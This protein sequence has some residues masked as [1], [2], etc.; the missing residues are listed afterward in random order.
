MSHQTYKEKLRRAMEDLKE[1]L[2]LEKDAVLSTSSETETLYPKIARVYVR[3]IVLAN[4]IEDCHHNIVHPQERLFVRKVLDALLVRLLE[5]KQKVIATSPREGSPHLFLSEVL[6]FL[7]ISPEQAVLRIPR[8]LKDDPAVAEQWDVKMQ[9]LEYWAT[10][11]RADAL[12]AWAAAS[13]IQA[14]W[15]AWSCR[16][17][18]EKERRTFL[19]FWG[20]DFVESAKLEDEERL[21]EQVFAARKL[22]QRE[23]GKAYHASLVTELEWLRENVGSELKFQKFA[24]GRDWMLEFRRQ[25]GSFPSSFADRTK[26]FDGVPPPPPDGRPYKI[27]LPGA[28]K[29]PEAKEKRKAEPSKKPESAREKKPAAVEPSEETLPTITDEL[30][31]LAKEFEATWAE[32]P[33]RVD[34]AQEPDKTLTRNQLLPQVESEVTVAVDE[35]LKQEL[36]RLRQQFDLVKEKPRKKGQKTGG[37]K[38]GKKGGTA[39]TKCCNA[40]NLAGPLEDIFPDLVKDGILRGVEP[41]KL[42]DFIGNFP[43]CPTPTDEFLPAPT[44]WQIKQFLVEQI[45]LPLASTSIREKT[46]FPARS[47]LLYG[48]PGS[49]KSLISRIIATEAG[50]MF[51]DLSPDVIENLYKHPKTGASLM[52]HKTFLCAQQHAP[53]VIYIDNVDQVFMSKKGGKKKGAGEQTQS[54]A[55][56]IRDQLKGHLNLVKKAGGPLSASDRLLVIGCTSRPFADRLDQKSMTDFFDHKLWLNFP[57]YETRK[58]IWESLLKKKHARIETLGLANLSTLAEMSDGYSGGALE[59]AVN[60]VFLEQRVAR[61]PDAPVQPAEMVGVLSRLPYCWPE[62]WIQFREFDFVATGEKARAAARKAKAEAEKA[63]ADKAKRN[64]K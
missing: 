59:A 62:E 47:L 42:D 14:V 16:R 35:L 1:L 58:M 21:L 9:K 46:P 41:A 56:R 29:K 49:G 22:F 11:L 40:A 3:Y 27:G 51:F 15:R 24:E 54:S 7:D 26:D 10:T 37:K 23:A 33:W 44:A 61:L 45:I 12:R 50:A 5:I 20:L 52:I 53:A 34:A 6:S 48:P 30:G 25:V 8:F 4:A 38:A 57:N 64:K 13:R 39:K 63:A 19:A 18:V 32:F 55:W 2:Q 43:V 17:R 60:H 31:E 36:V 28:D